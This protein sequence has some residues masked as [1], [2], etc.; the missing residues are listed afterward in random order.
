MFE[1]PVEEV[2]PLPLGFYIREESGYVLELVPLSHVESKEAL[3][4]HSINVMAQLSI[5]EP[6]ATSMAH[7]LRSCKR[8]KSL[9]A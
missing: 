2:E 1:S 8:G 4:N 9:N 5:S 3:H 6:A 7:H